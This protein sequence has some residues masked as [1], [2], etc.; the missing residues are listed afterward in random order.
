[1]SRTRL[2]A[3]V[4]IAALSLATATSASCPAPDRGVANF[5][6][7]GSPVYDALGSASNPQFRTRKEAEQ[8]CPDK[9]VVEVDSGPSIRDYYFTCRLN[10]LFFK[11]VNGR[12]QRMK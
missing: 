10:P 4:G 9:D 11:A 3:I 6:V 5:V 12:W 8:F 7:N 2:F 1:M